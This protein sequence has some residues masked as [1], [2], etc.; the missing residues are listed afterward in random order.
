MC[1]QKAEK[2][3][4]FLEKLRTIELKVASLKIPEGRWISIDPGSD[5]DFGILPNDLKS[6][7]TPDIN[8]CS[9][10]GARGG[11]DDILIGAEKYVSPMDVIWDLQRLYRLVE[12]F[13]A[14]SKMEQFQAAMAYEDCVFL[15]EAVAIGEHLDA[16]TFLSESEFREQ[17]KQELAAKGMDP[18]ILELCFDFERYAAIQYGYEDLYYSLA[19]ELYVH[20]TDDT[21]VP[22]RNTPP[23]HDSTQHGQI[24]Q[25][26]MGGM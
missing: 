9:L 13:Q 8:S 26:Q 20:K 24:Y 3:P 4:D 11:W 5:T 17:T 1:K 22:C 12:Q 19:T 10:L 16:Y 23:V 25:P 7:G 21:F 18:R 15:W 14:N 6:L 2:E